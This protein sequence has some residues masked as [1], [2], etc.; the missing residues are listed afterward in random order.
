M[1]N[2]MAWRKVNEAAW[3]NALMIMMSAYQ[4]LCCLFCFARHW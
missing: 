3:R 4:A 1:K 2:G